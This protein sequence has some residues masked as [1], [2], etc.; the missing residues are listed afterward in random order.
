[1]KQEIFNFANL[2]ICSVILFQF[3]VLSNARY[4]NK[5]HLIILIQSL[6]SLN[7]YI[8]LDAMVMVL[9]GATSV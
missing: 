1:M 4:V 5:L 6:L 3:Y 7:H 9:A 2:N 8:C